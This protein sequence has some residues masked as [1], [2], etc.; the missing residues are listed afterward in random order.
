[1][2]NKTESDDVI[3]TKAVDHLQ[4]LA[5]WLKLFIPLLIKLATSVFNRDDGRYPG[6]WDGLYSGYQLREE[7]M[8]SEFKFTAGAFAFHLTSIVDAFIEDVGFELK[9]NWYAKLDV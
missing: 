6:F 1:M 3:W 2:L 9:V 8:Y 5:N 4:E 7:M